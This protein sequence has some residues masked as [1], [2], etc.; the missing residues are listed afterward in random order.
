MDIR[1]FKNLK[2]VTLTNANIFFFEFLL[3]NQGIFFSFLYILKLDFKRTM[4]GFR[5][6]TRRIH[7]RVNKIPG[8]LTLSGVIM[9]QRINPLDLICLDFI[10]TFNC[11]SWITIYVFFTST[12]TNNKT[13]KHPSVIHSSIDVSKVMAKL[14][15]S[16]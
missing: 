15:N 8:G 2:A 10:K 6:Y 11:I 16:N 3:S 14:Q 12:M 13:W 4:R 9:D 1:S 7:C 5:L